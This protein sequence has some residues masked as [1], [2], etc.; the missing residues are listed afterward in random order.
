MHSNSRHIES[1][2]PGIHGQLSAQV[3]KPPTTEFQQSLAPCKHALEANP[4]AWRVGDAN[5]LV[6]PFLSA[7]QAQGAT[8][9]RACFPE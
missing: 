4:E 3:V 2:Q 7:T 9:H 1:N 5:R 6:L 8:G